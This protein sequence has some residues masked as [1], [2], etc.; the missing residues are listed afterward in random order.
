MS[1]AEAK[2]F[3]KYPGGKRELLPEIRKR[4]PSSE[5]VDVYVEPFVGGGAVLFDVLKT[6]RFERVVV[7]D[8]NAE[9]MN[10][11]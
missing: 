1:I 3:V 5:R 9:L 11:Y 8:I 2:P 7:S 10:V 4:Y 6:F